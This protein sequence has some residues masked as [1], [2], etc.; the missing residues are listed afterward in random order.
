[1]TRATVDN[2]NLLTPSQCSVVVAT[3]YTNAGAQP[4]LQ[5]WGSNSL[6]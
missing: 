5:S 6:I 2:V 1:M 4:L 3:V